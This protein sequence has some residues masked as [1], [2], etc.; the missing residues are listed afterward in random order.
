MSLEARRPMLSDAR[1]SPERDDALA[2]VAV[3]VDHERQ[4]RRS[5]SIR[6]ASSTWR[7]RAQGRRQHAHDATL[8]TTLQRVEPE[9]RVAQRPLNAQRVGSYEIVRMLARGGMAVVYLVRQPALDR[10]VV[11]KRLDLESDDPTH[12]AALRRRGAAGRDAQP[13]E[14]RH[15]VR[16]LRARRR[17]LHR[18]GVR[19]RRLAAVADRDARAAADLRPARGHAGRARP[20]GGPRHR[21]PRPQ[22]GERA[23]SRGAGT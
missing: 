3:E 16:L 6:C 4:P 23:A 8:I 20:R 1:A 17:A 22:A 2:A 13:P 14:R 18:D 19:R 15:A 12:R 5:A 11:L 21:P 7:D 10:E 9:R